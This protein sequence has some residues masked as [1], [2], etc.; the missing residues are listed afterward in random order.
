MAWYAIPAP[1]PGYLSA[2]STQH[3]ALEIVHRPVELVALLAV[4]RTLRSLRLDDLVVEG[5]LDLFGP[6]RVVLPQR[7]PIPVV[8]HHD[9][10]QVGVATEGDPEEVEDLALRPVR[11]RVEARD[12]IDPG[13]VLGH[14]GAQAQA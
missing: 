3:S 10:L 12:R 11:A 8:R 2:L 7:M 4:A 13:I 1:C 14:R 9:A 6:D 5:E